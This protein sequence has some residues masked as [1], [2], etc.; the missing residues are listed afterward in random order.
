MQWT[1]PDPGT[2]ERF[3]AAL[4]DDLSIERKKMF[5]YPAAFVNGNY[6]IGMHGDGMVVRLPG[7]L[8][9]AIPELAD[10]PIFD[11]R[12]TGKGMKDWYELPASITG[13]Q[14]RLA[15]V[16]ATLLPG[17]ATLPPKGKKLAKPRK[18]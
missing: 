15:E 8:R 11:P 2:V 7:D 16:I 13:N 10:A 9:A 12:E 3:H 18:S 17:V 5:G 6:F 4:P 14:E 1:K